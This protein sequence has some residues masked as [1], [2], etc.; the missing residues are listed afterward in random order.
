MSLR[1]TAWAIT[2][3]TFKDFSADR[4]PKLAAALAYY[5]IF[6][7]PGLLIIVIWITDIFYGKQAVEGTVY[8]QISSFVGH[9]AAL[10]IQETMR[11]SIITGN[12]WAAAAGVVSL[13]LGAS[14]VF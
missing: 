8:G 6:S 1:K 14:G 10:Q 7:L 2:K 13:V 4:V 12:N 9:D 3:N 11:N 5:T